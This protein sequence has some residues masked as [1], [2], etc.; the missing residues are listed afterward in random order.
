[1]SAHSI[2]DDLVATRKLRRRVPPPRRP[3]PRPRSLDSEQPSLD[4]APTLRMRR[5][6]VVTARA[7]ASTTKSPWDLPFTIDR[8]LLPSAL[9]PPPAAAGSRPE[10][11][12]STVSQHVAW[13]PTL[14]WLGAAAAVVV[15]TALVVL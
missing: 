12:M 10:A 8:T 15:V 2:D 1:M 3:Q 13:A 14:T 7:R 9:L 4:S 6:I 11:A 5:P